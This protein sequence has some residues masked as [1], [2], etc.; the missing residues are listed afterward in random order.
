MITYEKNIEMMYQKP[1]FQSGGGVFHTPWDIEWQDEPFA[2][3][4]ESVLSP[5]KMASILKDTWE[6]GI[7]T[8]ESAV[9]IH[10]PFCKLSCTYCAFYKK[11]ANEE[12]QH[13]YAKL[14]CKEIQAL[15]GRPYVEKSHIKSIFFGGGTPGIL[16]ASDISAIM[17]TIHDVFH[18][19]AD[20][21]ITMESSLSDMTD[22]KMDAAIA[23]GV[24]R[25][26]FG[27]Q[28]F[29]THIRN[30]IGRPLSREKAM[31]R[32]ARFAKK[33][34]LMILDLIYGLPGETVETMIQDI[35][36]AKACGAAG[37]DLYKLQLLPGSPL[38]KSFEKAGK[39]LETTYLQ[40]LFQ[41][42]ENEL[43]RTE[44]TNI[45]CTHW[46]WDERERSVYNTCASN[47]S[48]IIPLGMACGGKIGNIGLMKPMSETMYKGAVALGK[49]VPMGAKKQ[50]KYKRVY[51]AVESA[52]D[53][54]YIYPDELE[55]HYEV[56]FAT[57][58]TP[59]LDT[60]ECWGLLHKSDN[61]YRYTSAGRYW[62]R[63]ML[64]R[65]LHATQYMLC[66]EAG[67]KASKPKFGGMMNMK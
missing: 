50:S 62:Y 19:N 2:P 1:E 34:A 13:E 56:P 64:R 25:F 36:D 28:S 7:P 20:A 67:K 44:A 32:F 14:L 4:D 10:V 40:S 24:N 58:L 35:Q 23:G 5:I 49:F 6:N 30:G 16:S 18:L 38:T 54:G 21:E 29:Q 41:A 66:G 55:Q 63:T 52:G 39:K 47:G 26:S 3:C 45:S 65:L 15:K 59:L 46:K 42:A 53:T 8:D 9:Y 48:D 33:D 27:V 43:I 57:L 60:W 31:E 11:K 37:L 17:D 51:Q 22:E 12:E 61:C